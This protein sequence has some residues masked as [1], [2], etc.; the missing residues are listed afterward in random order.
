MKLKVLSLL[1]YLKELATDLMIFTGIF[2]IFIAIVI[3]TYNFIY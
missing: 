1:K 3:V 2:V